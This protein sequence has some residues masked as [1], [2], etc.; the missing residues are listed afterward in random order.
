MVP[1]CKHAERAEV[2]LDLDRFIY[3]FTVP[4][5]PNFERWLWIDQVRRCVDLIVNDVISL[6]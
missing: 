4:K 6:L 5:Y 2:I 1:I 3:L